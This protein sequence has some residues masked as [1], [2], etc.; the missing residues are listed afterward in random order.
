MLHLLDHLVHV[1]FLGATP[2]PLA[3]ETDFAR[4]YLKMRQAHDLRFNTLGL[5]SR[6]NSPQT[7][8]RVAA[9]AR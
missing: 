5:Q 2:L 1:I 3:P 6:R 4:R 9:V 8:L 7:N